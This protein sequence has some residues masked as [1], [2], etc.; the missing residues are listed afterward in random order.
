MNTA[1]PPFSHLK[2]NCS[3]RTI[4]MKQ[5]T[6]LHICSTNYVDLIWYDRRSCNR[7]NICQHICR[8][9]CRICTSWTVQCLRRPVFVLLFSTFRYKLYAMCRSKRFEPLIQFVFVVEMSFML[10]NIDFVNV[11]EM[12]DVFAM[13]GENGVAIQTW[14]SIRL[15]TYQCTTKSYEQN[16]KG[17]QT[18]SVIS[19]G[20]ASRRCSNSRRLLK[21]T[22]VHLSHSNFGASL[23]N[24]SFRAVCSKGTFGC[25]DL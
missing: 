20:W 16:M 2:T 9:S 1:S 3:T 21:A 23:A 18:F 14:N 5:T 6:Y 25:C 13:I 22:N 12:F 10:E 17:S 7:S 19:F 24:L 4:E 8:S 15:K 11:Y